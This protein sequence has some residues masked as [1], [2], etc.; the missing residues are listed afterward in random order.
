MPSSALSERETEILAFER[1]WWSHGGVK[2]TAIR[3]RF[4]LAAADYYQLLSGLID[5]PDALAHD[6][7]LIRRLRRQRLARRRERSVRRSRE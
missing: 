1:S 4:D 3:E 6:P 5:R 7:L 2:E